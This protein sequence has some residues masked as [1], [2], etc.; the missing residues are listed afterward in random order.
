METAEPPSRSVICLSRRICVQYTQ[1]YTKDFHGRKMKGIGRL[2]RDYYESEAEYEARMAKYSPAKGV[3]SC[4]GSSRGINIPS[5][6][7]TCQ[8][9]QTAD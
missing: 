1:M 6:S 4:R 8:L 7:L 3:W 2:L 5:K 9:Q